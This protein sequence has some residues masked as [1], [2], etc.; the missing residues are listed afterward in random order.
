MD[1]LLLIPLILSFFV[2]LIALPKW[3]NKAKQINLV[4]E[5]MNKNKKEKVSGSGGIIVILGFILA[6]LFYIAI[7]TFY[8]Q[9]SRNIVEIFSLT[10]SILMLAGT[11][12]IDDL[13]GWR[14]GGLSMKFRLFLCLFSAIPLIVINAGSNSI[15]LPFIDG[16]KLGLLY[17]LIF[18]PIGIIG[19]SASF[20][21][22]A[23]FNGLEAGQGIFILSALSVV[24]FFTGK[25][26][27]SLIALCMVFSLLAFWLFNKYPAK[28]FPGDVLT[29]PVGGL[30]AI[31][32]ILGNVE[33]IA[34]FFFIPYILEVFLKL[35][36]KLKKQSF[37]KP[38]RDGS[39]EMPYDK[40]YGLE[41][42]SIFLIK[43]FKKKVYEKDVVYSLY[44]LQALIIL[45]G[46]IIFRNSI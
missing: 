39:L 34:V 33:K 27:L 23:G 36:G 30:I 45:V 44:A 31:I 1:P 13:F 8:F 37:G 22:L 5:D 20:N 41:H 18:I 43:K 40:I 29:Y 42:L 7:K 2:V 14:H 26:W 9:D 28:V 12:F 19:A 6:I 15:S 10:T 17:P 35:R 32:A 38:N 21:M 16:I 46:F 3:I 4:W 11:G 25:T 24:T